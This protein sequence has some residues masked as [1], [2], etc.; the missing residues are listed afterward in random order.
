MIDEIGKMECLSDV[1][2]ERTKGALASSVPVV[3][4]VAAKG[5]GF[6]GDVKRRDD[7]EIVQVTPANRDALPDRIVQRLR[8]GCSSRGGSP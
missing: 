5:G 4:T 7:V 3:A 6:I 2:I 8:D 1:F